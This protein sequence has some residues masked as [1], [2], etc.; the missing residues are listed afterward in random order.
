MHKYTRT[1]APS[2]TH[3]LTHS[4]TQPGLHTWWSSSCCRRRARCTWLLI[5]CG[6]S[7]AGT[8]L[9]ERSC[10]SCALRAGSCTPSRLSPGTYLRTGLLQLRFVRW[11]VHAVKTGHV[12]VP[13]NGMHRLQK[14]AGVRQALQL[15]HG[16]LI[17]V[18]HQCARMQ[19]T[20]LC[21]C[22]AGAVQL[23]CCLPW[24]RLQ[25]VHVSRVRQPSHLSRTMLLAAQ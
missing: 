21:R 5:S 7:G 8:E 15:A 2:L 24:S 10:S 6:V 25:H 12:H 17:T 14:E 23:R 20:H 4:L 16:L 11:V 1:L 3:S 13:E 19:H 18:K 22:G 9:H